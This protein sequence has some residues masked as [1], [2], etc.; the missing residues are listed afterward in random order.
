MGHLMRRLAVN[1]FALIAATPWALADPA[2][3]MGERMPYDAFD[4]LPKTS[5]EV[6]GAKLEVAFAPGT[7]AC[8]LIVG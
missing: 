2:A 7:F 5:I 4:V 8:T 3:Y 1:L 6:A